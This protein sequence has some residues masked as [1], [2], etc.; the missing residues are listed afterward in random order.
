[1][2]YSSL[3]GLFCVG[4]SPLALSATTS[5]GGFGAGEC[6]QFPRR[7]R[8]QEQQTEFAETDPLREAA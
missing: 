1:M 2:R 5:T 6:Q 7:R 8:R 3:I 4:A